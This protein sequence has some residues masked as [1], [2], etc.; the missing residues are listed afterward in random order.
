M[1]RVLVSAYACEPG[2]GSEPGVGWNWVCQISRFSEVWVITRANNRKVIEFELSEH[3]LS[4]IHFIYFDLPFWLRFW[5]RPTHGVRLYYYL[6]QFSAYLV[7]RQLHKKV[8]FDIAH[9][10]TFVSYWTPSFL[11]LLPIPFVLG[12]VGG[13]ESCPSGF[14]R[15][16]GIRGKA[17][18]LVRGFART[19]AQFDPFVRMTV[20]RSAVA[21]ATTSETVERLQRLGCQCTSVLSQVALSREEVGDMPAPQRR[22]QNGFHV[23]SVG[24][25]LHWKGFEFGL[26]A[27]ARTKQ[28]FPDATYSLVGNG[29]EKARLMALA[30]RLGIGDH[31][32]FVGG[33]SR[34]HTL[35]KMADCDVLLNPSL[36]DSGSCVC[37]EAMAVG[38]PVICL[39]LGGPALQV[40]DRTGIKIPAISPEQVIRDLAGAI[41]AL[42]SDP[43]YLER[44][45][46]SA[47][48]QVRECSL[49]ETK[50]E[51]IFALYNHILGRHESSAG[52]CVNASRKDC[53]GL[54]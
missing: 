38:I 37:A 25:L 23:L 48:K 34:Q 14:W 7:A 45:G 10:V 42:A 15:S 3:S 21:L 27:F 40:S 4:N 24:R 52:A 32:H 2:R 47:R 5:K 31:V 13:G 39:D 35:E 18:E 26:R 50:G 33:L 51:L 46:R 36:H 41:T 8:R 1:L 9:H 11:A 22:H 29:P 49:W 30:R 20:R 19:V 16:F 6:W 43:L 17:Y 44:L 54:L 12:P 53:G 28:Q